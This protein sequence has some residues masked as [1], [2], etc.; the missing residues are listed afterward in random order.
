MCRGVIAAGSVIGSGSAYKGRA[1][2]MP[3]MGPV[4][5]VVLFVL[6]QGVQQVRLVP[7]QRPTEQFMAAG[8]NPPLHDRVHA[9]RSHR[10]EHDR[11]TGVGEDR[12][13][14]R[15]VLSV[16]IT[17]EVLDLAAGVVEVHEQVPGRLGH[18]CGG[19]VG[20]GA[21]DANPAGGV[22]DDGKDIQASTGQ[23]RC[24]E[25]VGGEDGVGLAE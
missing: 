9:R 3:P 25:E 19:R 11:D 2:A 15:R 6:A 22:L 4:A 1:F 13:E 18:P 17:D 8:L 5:V 12:V 23:R 21:E 7:D 14:Q 20:G 24:F 16:T 10:A